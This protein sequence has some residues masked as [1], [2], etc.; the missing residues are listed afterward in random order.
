MQAVSRC[1]YTLKLILQGAFVPIQGR[2]RLHRVKNMGQKK[3]NRY[4]FTVFTHR[5]TFSFI[6][7]IFMHSSGDCWLYLPIDLVFL[8]SDCQA[9]WKL[10]Y[11]WCGVNPVVRG[12]KATASSYISHT[13]NM[14]HSSKAMPCKLALATHLYGLHFDIR[15]GQTWYCC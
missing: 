4:I 11:F 9:R 6:N 2:R 14:V 5:F 8:Q 1:N 15:Y 7:K 3:I 12:I 13:G 10:W